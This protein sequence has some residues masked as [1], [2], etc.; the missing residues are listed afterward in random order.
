L[1]EG[2]VNGPFLQ[3]LQREEE[4]KELVEVEVEVWRKMENERKKRE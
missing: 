4:K 1:F 3:S 2:V